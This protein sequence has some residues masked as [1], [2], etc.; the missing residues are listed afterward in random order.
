MR[1]EEVKESISKVETNEDLVEL[2]KNLRVLSSN[3]KSNYVLELIE[4][5]IDISKEMGNEITLINLFELKIKQLFHIP[6]QLESATRILEEMLNLSKRVK[7]QE[8]LALAYSTKWGI[9]K[10]KGNKE[11]SLQ[12]MK[13]S[14]EIVEKIG[15]RDPYVYHICKYTYGIEIWLEHHMIECVTIF[16]ECIPYF[17]RNGFN[18]GFIQSLGILSVIYSKTQD[19]RKLDEL[20]K[21]VL[22]DRTF[23]NKQSEDIQAMVF[24]FIGISQIIQYDL[25]FAQI[26]LKEAYIRWKRLQKKSSYYYYYYIRLL[27]H[28]ATA[29]A[30][31]G[32][33]AESF[34]TLRE[35]KTLLEDEHYLD[36]L[37]HHSKK[38]V[39]HTANLI[40]FYVYSRKYEFD[41]D[42]MEPLIMKII[43][44]LK[45]QYSNPIM[46]I[47][48][49]LNAKLSISQLENIKIIE[50]VSILRVQHIIEYLIEKQKAKGEK[51]EKLNTM[52]LISILR[53]QKEI[54]KTSFTEKAF[55][56][57][58]IAKELYSIDEFDEIHLLLNKYKNNLEKIEVLELKIFMD[59]FIQ[60]G[61]FKNGNPL[62]PALQYVSIRNCKAFGF[63]KLEHILIKHQQKMY[64]FAFK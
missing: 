16:E 46:L 30:L 48:F 61:E 33:L 40:K 24:Y 41:K 53:N 32:D 42:D 59:A 37:D 43:E 23:F 57:L 1:L 36:N 2:I 39:P 19:V 4:K 31:K 7:Y 26:H 13:K 63:T 27:S 15:K 12:A 64:E 18:R 52:G 54:T 11:Q 56:D 28:I 58:L 49:L 21:I 22:S 5:T 3:E 55:S 17:Y 29:Q 44:G 51:E 60:I 6:Q 47:E 62:A 35:I 38:Q 8:G 10:Y 25:E 50:N 9:E 20:S 34:L 14:I 45:E